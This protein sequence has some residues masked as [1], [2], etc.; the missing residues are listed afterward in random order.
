V[1]FAEGYSGCQLHQRVECITDAK[2]PIHLN[3]LKPEYNLTRSHF[4]AL[5]SQ[6]HV[7]FSFANGI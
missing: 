5:S 4:D 1:Y 6:S 7:S 3:P 2:M